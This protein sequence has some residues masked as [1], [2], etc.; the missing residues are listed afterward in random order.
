M[1]FDILAASNNQCDIL[2]FE[3]T[4]TETNCFHRFILTTAHNQQI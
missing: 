4:M 1:H 2:C 3:G